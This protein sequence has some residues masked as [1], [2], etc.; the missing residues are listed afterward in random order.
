MGDE[1]CEDAMHGAAVC[2]VA[3]GPGAVRYEQHLVSGPWEKVSVSAPSGQTP[4]IVHQAIH[5]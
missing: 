4:N 2:Q 1:V 5:I 3:Q